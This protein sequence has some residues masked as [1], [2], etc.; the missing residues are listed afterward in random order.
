MEI[1]L[2]MVK[3]GSFL[4]GF[5]C[6]FGSVKRAEP[7]LTVS[8]LNL[9][10][11]TGGS[12]IK[13]RPSQAGSTFASVSVVTIISSRREPK[14]ADRII[15]TITIFVVYLFWPFTI[16]IEPSKMMLI[17][18]RIANTYLAVAMASWRTNSVASTDWSTTKLG[19]EES[20]L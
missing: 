17:V 10:K 15:T 2:S 7:N 5:V 11:P 4:I 9:R 20:S 14:I 1:E 3:F 16:D 13:V 12:R 6:L 18:F 8:E 19:I